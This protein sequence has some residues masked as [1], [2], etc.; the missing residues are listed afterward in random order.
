MKK[1]SFKLKMLPHMTS[2][3]EGIYFLQWLRILI[4][5]IEGMVHRLIS[6]FFFVE[7][8]EIENK[9]YRK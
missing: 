1:I 6:F 7:L 3:V 8:K 4:H 9:K 2:L 5:R